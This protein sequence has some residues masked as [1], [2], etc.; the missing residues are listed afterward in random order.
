MTWGSDDNA[1]RE[2]EPGRLE[3]LDDPV[4]RFW[5]AYVSAEVAG[6][7]LQVEGNACLVIDVAKGV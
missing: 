6:D 5:G 4:M 2:S 3:Q 7:R 1:N